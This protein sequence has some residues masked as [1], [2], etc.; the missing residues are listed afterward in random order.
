MRWT[1]LRAGSNL[2]NVAG[3]AGGIGLDALYIRRATGDDDHVPSNHDHIVRLPWLETDVSPQ[4]M[5]LIQQRCTGGI[6]GE[7]S[8]GDEIGDL[9]EI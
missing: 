1:V 7:F 5:E 9:R 8:R 4:G 2:G 6:R 3:G